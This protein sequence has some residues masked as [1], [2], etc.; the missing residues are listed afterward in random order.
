MYESIMAFQFDLELLCNGTL[1]RF[2]FVTN[3]TDGKGDVPFS[4]ICC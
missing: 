4:P 3:D 1:I 2:K